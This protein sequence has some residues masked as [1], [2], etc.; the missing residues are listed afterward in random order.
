MKLSF[1]SLAFFLILL[2]SYVHA[3]ST[4]EEAVGAAG[5]KRTRSD[6]QSPESGAA[7]LEAP[8]DGTTSSLSSLTLCSA[9]TAAA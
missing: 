3:A 8:V 6:I 7:S 9:A 4:S 1:L 5:S 2:P